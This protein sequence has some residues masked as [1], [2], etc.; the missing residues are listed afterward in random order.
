[1]APT[2]LKSPGELA[3]MR[4]AGRLVAGALRLL[5]DIAEPGLTTGQLDRA[6]ADYIGEHDAVPA[7]K[8]YRGF[9]GNICTSIN[10]EV[11]HGIPGPR[12]LKQGDLLKL[13]VGV[14]WEGYFGDGAVTVPIGEVSE[15]ARRL[16]QVTRQALGCAI[17]VLRDGVGVSEV[18]AAIQQEVERHGLSVVTEYTG[19]GIGR[20]LHEDPKVPNFVVSGWMRRDVVLR[21]GAV[22]AIEP[23]VNMGTE[24]TEVLPN[25]WTVVTRDRQPSAHFEHTVA[26][27]EDGPV[28][29]TLP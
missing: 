20:A 19:H 26:I 1:M 14:I 4:Q 21:K 10:E 3:K 9:P 22:V 28:I 23:M 16:V 13:D 8:G 7:F 27:D 12:K 6:A 24:K 2:E 17:A 11:V 15:A 25:K 5:E 18:S 29:L